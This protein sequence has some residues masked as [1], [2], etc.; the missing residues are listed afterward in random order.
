MFNQLFNADS[1]RSL[2]RL[3]ALLIMLFVLVNVLQ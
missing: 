2:I 3:V 1:L